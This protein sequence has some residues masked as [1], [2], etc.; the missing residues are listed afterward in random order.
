MSGGQSNQTSTYGETFSYQYS[1]PCA[2]TGPVPTFTYTNKGEVASGHAGT[3]TLTR[4]AAVSCI[5][6]L[7]STAGPG[8]YDSLQFTAYGTWSADS[9]PHF[10][11]VNVSTNPS[12]PYI[13]ILIDGNTLSNAD[14]AP[15]LA[16]VP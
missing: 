3:F 12:A 9:N 1:I 4:L 14:I 16:P 7:T 8:N 15:T 13:S 6:S 10:A 5:N 11:T 2:G